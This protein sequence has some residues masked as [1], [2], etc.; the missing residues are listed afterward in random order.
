MCFAG[1]IGVSN[2]GL[3]QCHFP[4]TAH[5]HTITYR[6]QPEATSTSLVLHVR[7]SFWSSANG[8][9]T[10]VLPTQW[11]GG[12]L[13][14]MTNLRVVSRDASLE[15]GTDADAMIV[16]APARH[17]VVI[18]YDL[19]KDWNGPLVNPLQFHPVLMPEYV[20]FTGSNAL[21]RIKLDDQAIETANFDWRAIPAA[22][23]LATSFGTS[24]SAA[25][26]CQTFTGPWREVN[27][28]LYAAGDF[29]I[30]KFQINGSPA[31]LAVRG[32]WIF[33]DDDAVKDIQSVVGMVRNFWHDDNFPFFLVTLSPY[34]QDHGSSDGSAFTSAFW[35][36]VSRLDSINGLLPQLAHESFHAW[37]PGRMG[38]VP[39]GYDQDLI[40]WFRE[41]PTEYYAQLLTY[42]AGELTS[43][44]YINS[45]NAVLRRFP[46]SNDEYV[47]GRIISLWLDGTIR[48][49]SD[50][51]HSLDDVMF[52]MM[53]TGDQPYTLDR[54][55]ST[56]GRYLS[57]GSRALLEQAV[58]H[59]GDLPAPEHLPVLGGCTHASLD[60]VP[61]FDLGFDFDRSRSTGTVAGVV[62]NGPAFNAG[63]RDGQRLLANSF[64]R[65]DPKHVAKFKVHTDAGDQQ[66]EYYPRGKTIPAWQYHIDQDKP[67]SLPQNGEQP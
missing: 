45:I 64:Y 38:A 27:E 39:T 65:H 54:I 20:E 49:E 12:T 35:M 23:A 22:W 44:E 36:F 66:I 41:G 61:T 63:L 13:H 31:F 5:E 4:A 67:C 2:A 52:D 26:R 25:D 7:F 14:A 59:H 37:D 57:P 9:Q 17:K 33:S 34:D 32:A 10:L 51:Q 24:A 18:A 21:V 53:R 1:L 28:G 40:K 47:R 29:R 8:T 3:A 60:D 16:R 46:V 15:K 42:R 50:G 6:F 62:E 55:L 11:A 56:A 30:H 58:I 43:S 19:Y 48:R